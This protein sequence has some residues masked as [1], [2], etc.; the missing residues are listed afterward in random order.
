MT[1]LEI[2]ETIARLRRTPLGSNVQVDAFLRG[3]EQFAIQTNKGVASTP[4]PVATAVASTCSTCAARRAGKAQ[5]QKRW[6]GKRR[7]SA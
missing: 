2:L 4:A 1:G 7:P 6:R 3:V 5:A